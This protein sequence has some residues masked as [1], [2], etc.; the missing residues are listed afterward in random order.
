MIFKSFF[1]GL[2]EVIGEA[3]FTNAAGWPASYQKLDITCP[4]CNHFWLS[5]QVLGSTLKISYCMERIPITET[6]KGGVTRHSSRPCDCTNGRADLL[7]WYQRTQ[8]RGLTPA[9]PMC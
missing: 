5:H 2:K 3:L 8:K 4:D 1:Q 9:R 6:T 7:D